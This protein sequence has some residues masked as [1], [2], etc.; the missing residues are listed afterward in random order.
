MLRFCVSALCGRFS[1]CL[2]PR[3]AIV[4]S[5]SA[6]TDPTANSRSPPGH[7]FPAVGD[8]RAREQIV[9]AFLVNMPTF[10]WPVL[11]LLSW[12]GQR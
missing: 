12:M 11:L 2:W 4:C 5:G 10:R 1:A 3:D 6:A 9:G 8:P 7:S